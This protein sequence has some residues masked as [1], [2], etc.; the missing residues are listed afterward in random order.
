MFVLLMIRNNNLKIIT[1][2]MLIIKKVF[3][4]NLTLLSLS[5]IQKLAKTILNI[6]KIETPIC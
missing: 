5:F 2:I 3:Q 1:N 6:S 4:K